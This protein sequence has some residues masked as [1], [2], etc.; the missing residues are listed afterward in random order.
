MQQSEINVIALC[1]EDSISYFV[2][3]D[4]EGKVTDLELGRG[5][6]CRL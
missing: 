6:S 3:S 4:G 1:F 2:L 5:K